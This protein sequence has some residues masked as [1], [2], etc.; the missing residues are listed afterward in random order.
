VQCKGKTAKTKVS[1]AT[2]INLKSGSIADLSDDFFSV[3]SAV[4][5]A[6][7]SG[8]LPLPVKEM[9]RRRKSW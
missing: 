5:S 4:F 6:V 8:A 2:T 1:T 7:F 3:F 9:K